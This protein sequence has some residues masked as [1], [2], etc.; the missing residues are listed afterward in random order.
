MHE[1]SLAIALLRQV[2]RLMHQHAAQRI[3]E[4]KVI[5]GEFTGIE[6]ALLES[7]FVQ[8]ALDGPARGSRLVMKRSPL[9]A[10][11]QD[12]MHTFRIRNYAFVCPVCEGQN[13]GIV[14]GE[15]LML[16]SVTMETDE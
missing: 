16:E 11:C 5:V 7:A 10:Q 3:T 14:R 4:V 9:E 8:A 12:C 15:E 6:A 13:I 1:R 2:E